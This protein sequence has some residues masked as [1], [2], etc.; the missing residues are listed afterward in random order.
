MDALVRLNVAKRY[1]GRS[2]AAVADVSMVVARGEVVAIMGPSGN[3]KSTCWPLCRSRLNPHVITVA[4]FV[5]RMVS[6]RASL[7]C[8]SPAW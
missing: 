6:L 2:A 4:A 3:R 1:D 7:I 5:S 8:R